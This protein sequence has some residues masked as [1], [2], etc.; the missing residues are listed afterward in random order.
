MSRQW[1]IASKAGWLLITDAIST[2]VM[3]ADRV[4]LFGTTSGGFAITA[5][6]ER[7]FFE[8]QPDHAKV[9]VDRLIGLLADA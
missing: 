4:A 1:E 7:M 8:C 3:E 6:G 5:A 9:C 2:T